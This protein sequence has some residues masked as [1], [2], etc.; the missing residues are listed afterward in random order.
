MSTRRDFLLQTASA[1]VVVASS[2]QNAGVTHRETLVELKSTMKTH[3][4]PHTDLVVSRI[5][6][7]TNFASFDGK[8]SNFLERAVRVLRSAFDNGINLFDLANFYQIGRSEEA[9]GELLRQSPELRQKIVIQ[10]KC[11]LVPREG[12]P[13]YYDLSRENIIAS[14]EGSLERLRTDHLDILLLHYPD[15]LSEPA[16]IAEAFERLKQNG[17]VRYFGVSNYNVSQL[18]LLRRHV[19]QP[20]VANQIQL[21]VGNCFPLAPASMRSVGCGPIIDYCRLNDIQVQAYSPLALNNGGS[22]LSPPID[23]SPEV[24]NAAEALADIAKLR[25]VGPDSI[26]LAWL[27]RHPAK[28]VPIIGSTNAEHIL[29]NCAADRVDLTREE[30]DRLF[31][32]ALKIQGL[33]Q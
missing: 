15:P 9:L 1:G 2:T 4:I 5:A 26:A 6:Y 7:G 3:R 31:S 10:S 13:F 19:R 18:E 27:L 20:L 16:E 21:G 33:G 29:Q 17:K 28:I 25:E 30:W 22:L 8:S 24:K 23:T 14:T 32:A 12:P 11:G